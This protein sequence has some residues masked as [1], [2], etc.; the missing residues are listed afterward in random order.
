MNPSDLIV[1][2]ALGLPIEQAVDLLKWYVA[3]DLE[4]VM[5]PSIFWWCNLRKNDVA[6]HYFNPIKEDL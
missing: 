1:L 5:H 3:H 4:E 2:C 6:E